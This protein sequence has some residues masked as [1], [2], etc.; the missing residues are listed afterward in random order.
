MC[1]FNTFLRLIG[2]WV[3]FFCRDFEHKDKILSLEQAQCKEDFIALSNINNNNNNNN[4]NNNNSNNN[5]GLSN[6]ASNIYTDKQKSSKT[7]KVTK[8]KSLRRSPYP[9]HYDYLASSSGDA[10]GGKNFEFLYKF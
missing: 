10:T 3:L 7:S 6:I 8:S 5:N 1:F 9:R 2:L 4:I